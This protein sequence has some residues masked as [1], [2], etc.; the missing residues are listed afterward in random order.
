MEEKLE[1]L[2]TES[3]NEQ[4]MQIDTAEPIEILRLM[5]EQDQLVALA[6]K[7]VLS[8]IEVAVQYVFESFQKGGRLIYVGAGT[9]GRLGVLDAVECP[10]TFGTDPEMVQGLIA[11]GETAFFKAV[12]GAEDQPDLGIKDLKAISLSKND[13]VIG[14]AASGR[15]PY[16]IGALQYARAVGAK[17]IALS[18]NKNAD[19]SKEAE[20][21]IEVIVGPEVLTGS[22]RL[23]SGTAHKMI[24]NMISTSSMIL[25]GKAY[26]NLMVD[27]HVS[28]EKLKERAI[29]IICKIADVSYEQALET[30][31]EAN[32]QV[33]TAIVML[34]TNSSKQEAEQLLANANGYVKKAIQ[35]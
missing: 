1:L 5:N 14:I 16:V 31:E 2:T 18:C 34:K 26:E 10:P 7:E 21:A 19:I 8:D 17:T 22:T 11:G 27:V 30:L 13:T 25:L 12:E 9:S 28:N 3:R 24:L 33:K 4:T 23:K 32:L 35:K 15:T 6:V 20:Q 29:A